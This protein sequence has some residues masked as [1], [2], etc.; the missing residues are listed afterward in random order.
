MSTQRYA[1]I[2]T[3]PDLGYG[4]ETWTHYFPTEHVARWNLAKLRRVYPY[5][6]YET[7]GFEDH[8]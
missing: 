7:I 6:T 8:S 3:Y 1:I 2:E 4:P 5:R